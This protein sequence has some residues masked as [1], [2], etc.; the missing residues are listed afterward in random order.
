MGARAVCVVPLPTHRVRCP[1]S[2][3]GRHELRRWRVGRGPWR[4]GVFRLLGRWGHG[5]GQESEPLAVCMAKGEQNVA[6]VKCATLAY[7]LF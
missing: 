3:R 2:C 5:G 1:A 7:G 6:T 4:V